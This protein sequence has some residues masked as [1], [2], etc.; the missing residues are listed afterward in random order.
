MV[1]HYQIL[2]TILLFVVVLGLIKVFGGKEKIV[3]LLALQLL[4]TSTVALILLLAQQLQL[5]GLRDLAL[6]MG[7]L[8]C[9]VAI[10]FVH[11]VKFNS[12]NTL[13][14]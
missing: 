10:A 14:K 8:A 5:E 4:G 2:A 1:E 9:I 11:Y 13:K 6:I 3:Q 12:E 7:L